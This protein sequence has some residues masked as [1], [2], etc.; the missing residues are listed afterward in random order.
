[1]T[2]ASVRNWLI[3]T[4]RTAN[5]LRHTRQRAGGHR[6]R[7]GLR[8]EVLDERM[9]LTATAELPSGQYLNALQ[10]L[11]TP[12][13]DTVVSNLLADYNIPGMAVAI[14]YQ[15]SVI[16][17][18]GYGYTGDSA[19]TD[20]SA[21]P[22]VTVNTPFDIGSVT[23]TFTAISI[24]KIVQDP[25][26]IDTSTNPGITSL[27]L[28]A[29]ISTYLPPGT[30]ISLPGLAPTAP[31]FTLPTNWGN[32]TTR[33]LLSMESGVPDVSKSI[34]WNEVIAQLIGP[35]GT[36]PLEFSPPGS[37]YYY[38][39][40]GFNILGAMIEKLTNMTYAQF[41]QQ[42]IFTPLG[43][44]QSTVLTGTNT[45]VAGEAVGYNVYD[46]TTGTG[47]PTPADE[48]ETGDGGFASGNIVSTGQDLGAYL[49]ALLEPIATAARFEPIPVDVDSGNA[50]ILRGTQHNLD[51][52]TGMGWRRRDE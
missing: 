42:E 17:D 12:K 30:P 49:A 24:L 9:L 28:D 14:T 52:R 21:T 47:T 13:V 48:L 15:G 43:M 29:P 46:A 36:A 23:K 45:Q 37:Y 10:T 40:T 27:Q 5:R 44:D 26:L 4:E 7:V 11:V 6:G 35:D 1:M 22:P 39:D 41:V 19:G 18:R 32:L 3:I 31:T 2:Q 51:A 50:H 25:S 16:L 38:S 33:E 8:V 34:A 20:A